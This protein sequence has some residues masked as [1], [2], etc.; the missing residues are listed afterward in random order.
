MS[1]PHRRLCFLLDTAR[2]AYADYL[3]GGQRFREAQRLYA[4]NTRIETLL[5]EKGDVWPE[6]NWP[7]VAALLQHLHKLGVI[8]RA[9][10]RS[11]ASC[12]APGP[13]LTLHRSLT[14]V[15]SRCRACR[16]LEA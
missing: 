7:H 15:P 6:A 14:P 1:A 13:P 5:L 3:A 11:N 8:Y 12:T 9:R 10:R 4:V 16:R 2:V